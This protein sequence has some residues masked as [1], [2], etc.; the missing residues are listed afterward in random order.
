[1]PAG[2]G[3]GVF[4]SHALQPGDLVMCVQ[5]LAVVHGE[6]DSMPEPSSLLGP[7][8]ALR[9]AAWGSGSRQQGVHA[10]PH[11]IR[12]WLGLLH[13]E[14]RVEGGGSSERQE[15]RGPAMRASTQL[16]TELATLNTLLH[17]PLQQEPAKSGISGAGGGAGA[18]GP[19][20]TSSTAQ[21]AAP[22]ES[23][24]DAL[25]AGTA[26]G[27][28]FEDLGA[29]DCKKKEAANSSSQREGS[30]QGEQQ[31]TSHV[32][33]WPHFAL[34]NHSCLPSCVHYVVGS[35]MVVRAV[36]EVAPGT[37]VRGMRLWSWDCSTLKQHL[38]TPSTHFLPHML[39]T[40]S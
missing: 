32:G 28:S 39:D 22:S 14:H 6:A 21:A 37:E 8:R 15:Q 26:F 2:S 40:C 10:H 9:D 1:M 16:G 20:A 7:L 19:A 4:T 5:P 25:I 27:D 23:D 11:A 38:I 33:L 31:P 36:R 12:Q 17:S 24:L 3:R 18:A 29:F 30:G 34:F 35:S 13:R